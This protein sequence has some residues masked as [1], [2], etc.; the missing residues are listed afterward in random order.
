MIALRIF[1]LSLPFLLAQPAW[2]LVT[3]PVLRSFI[4]GAVV[5]VVPGLPWSGRAIRR[6]WPRELAWLVA[7]AASLAIFVGV[8][9]VF[10][11]T[12]VTLTGSRAWNAVWLATV[13]GALLNR[14]RLAP[15]DVFPQAGCHWRLASASW[16]RLPICLERTA[17]WQP[18][19]RHWQDASGTRS[20]PCLVPVLMAVAF[21]LF[22]FGATWVVPPM[23]DQDF[24]VLGCGYGLLTR[25]EPL[26]VS[27]HETVYQFSHPPLAYFCTAASFLYFNQLDY[28]E[29]YDAA[30]RRALAAK[31][32]RDF[33]PFGGTVDGLS[34][35]VGRH[36]VIGRQGEDYLVDPPLKTHSRAIPVWLLENGVLGE[37]YHHDPQRLAARTANIFLAALTVALLGSWIARR[38]GSSAMAILAALVYATSPEIFVRSS[39]GGHFA[40]TNFAVLMVLMALDVFLSLRERPVFLSLR[41]R[42]VFLSLR[43]RLDRPLSPTATVDTSRSEVNTTDTSRSEVNTMERSEVNTCIS[44]GEMRTGAAMCLLAGSFAAVTNHKLIPLFAA[45]A[46]WAFFFFFRQRNTKPASSAV[47][48]RL[49][50]ACYAAAC[51]LAGFAAGTLAF[52]LW[53]LGIA[54]AEFWRD[55]V[56]THFVDR[57]LHHA[58][59]YAGDEYPSIA[60]LWGELWQHT[61]YLLLPLAG[62]AIGVEGVRQRRQSP[63]LWLVWTLLAAMAFSLVDWRQTKH[64]MP[65]M[66]PICMAPACW[67][68]RGKVQRNLVTIVFAGLVAWN[69]WTICGLAVN[70]ASMA[71]TPGW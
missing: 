68:L 9:I 5:L 16:G 25:M 20:V 56:L 1:V 26:L 35:G 46:V 55:H 70:F 33:Q 15:R 61:G 14:T 57:L 40:T 31:Q 13:L 23:E 65:L 71:T 41:E 45:I 10:R 64:L 42:L 54:P 2:P 28:L 19:P 24:D 37:Y 49:P 62:V 7:V 29:Y 52:W 44:Q 27:D 51:C 12:G 21:A 58:N 47:G 63:G 32:G 36:R 6:G 50:A 34:D 17:D 48:Y 60:G 22:F 4:I 53:G 30:S 3:V 43:E 11:L 59:A 8:L 18:A 66:I 69:V 38:T 67:A 39:Y